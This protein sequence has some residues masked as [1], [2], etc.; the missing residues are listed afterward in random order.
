MQQKV[1]FKE[2][3]IDGAIHHCAG[4]ELK[5]K[6]ARQYPNGCN[7]GHS[8]ITDAVGCNLLCKYVI[9]TVRPQTKH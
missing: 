6:C 1:T 5:I 3:M 8:V 9:H 7:E 2:A 4:K